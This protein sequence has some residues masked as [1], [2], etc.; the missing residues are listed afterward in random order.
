[1]Y[2]AWF[3][4]ASWPNPNGPSACGAVIKRD[5]VIVAELSEYLG[6]A[7]TSNNLAEYAGLCL[8]LRYFIEHGITEAKVFGDADMIVNQI[9]G[10]W[11]VKRKKNPIYLPKYDEARALADQLPLVTYEWIPRD[12]NTEAD[13]LSTKPLIERGFREPVYPRRKYTVA[14]N[15]WQ[16]YNR[17]INDRFRA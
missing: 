17:A 1:M 6:D 16:P 12:L 10:K 7:N 5:G 11:K 4:G 13:A 15:R 9:S 3:D 14:P 2:T 8:V